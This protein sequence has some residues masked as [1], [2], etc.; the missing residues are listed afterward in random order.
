MEDFI[1]FTLKEGMWCIQAR[2]AKK[3]VFDGQTMNMCDEY[4]TKDKLSD[5]RCRL[6]RRE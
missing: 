3:E 6:G 2:R 1:G 5:Y 4:G